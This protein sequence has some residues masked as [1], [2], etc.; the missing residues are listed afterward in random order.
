MEITKDV[1]LKIMP[2]AKNRVD[3][4]LPWLNKYALEYGVTTAMRWCHYLAQIAVESAELRYTSEIASGAA[5]DTGR[6]AVK[7]GNTPQKDGD[8][9]RYKGGGLLQITGLDNYKDISKD[10]GIDFVGHPELLTTPQY[11]VLSSFWYWG[12]HHLNALSDKD[13][14]TKIREA[15]NGGHNGFKEGLEYLGKAKRAMGL[16][17]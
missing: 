16:L 1:L 2:F 9:E 5:Y 12:K 11:A 13:E 7:L 15:I 8:G 17:K 14:Y 6:L 4:F 10:L 3:L